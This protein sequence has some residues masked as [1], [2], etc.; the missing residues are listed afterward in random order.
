MRT[1]ELGASIVAPLPDT[2]EEIRKVRG[3]IDHS[4]EAIVGRP[5]RSRV[6]ASVHVTCKW[7]VN[8]DEAEDLAAKL[9]AAGLTTVIFDAEE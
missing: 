7:T 9:R 5:A 6:M 2:G 4:M 3:A 8:A 1:V